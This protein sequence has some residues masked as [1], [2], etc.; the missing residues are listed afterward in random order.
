MGY[1]V[2]D[3]GFR[4]MIAGPLNIR[5]LQERR[6]AQEAANDLWPNWPIQ[7]DEVNYS[8]IKIL[9]MMRELRVYIGLQMEMMGCT[10]S[11]IYRI[12][13]QEDTTFHPDVYVAV[14]LEA[15]KGLRA[16]LALGI[17]GNFDKE[18]GSEH[19]KL[20]SYLSGIHRQVR[21]LR[22]EREAWQK[23]WPDE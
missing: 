2:N 12:N 9:E 14:C 8:L 22:K 6:M 21:K 13:G 16:H 23:R 17:W 10:A 1:P 18:R 20:L 5:K 7:R 4:L 11:R 15:R 3:V 19:R